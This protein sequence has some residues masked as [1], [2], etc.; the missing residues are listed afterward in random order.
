MPAPQVT[1]ERVTPT[2]L[3][4]DGASWS[5]LVQA[6][7]CDPLFLG[8]D[9]QQL[10]W[11]IYSVP[12]GGTP[13]MYR[14]RGPAGELL[15]I[16]PLYVRRAWRIGP[17]PLRTLEFVGSSWR[18]D[19]TML[20]EYIGPIASPELMPQITAKLLT[21]IEADN[22]CDEFV[23]ALTP[24]TAAFALELAALSQRRGW[25]LRDHDFSRAYHV[26]LREGFEGYLQRLSASSRRHLFN[27]RRRLARQGSLS[28]ESFQ[29]E[30]A[31]TAF[32]TLN[33]LHALRWGGPAFSGKRLQFHQE[34]AARSTSSR[35][36]IVSVLSC[37]AR[38][39]SAL[40]DVR[41]GTRQYNLQMGFDAAA[42]RSVSIGLLHLGHALEQASHAGVCLY[43]MLGGGGKHTQYKAA[44][45]NQHT[46]LHTAQAIRAPVPRM[47]YRLADTIRGRRRSMV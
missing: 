44:L 45:S 11:Q 32:D 40:Y 30:A 27:H 16:V 26:D 33:Q 21:T 20:T 9:W 38:P 17:L 6:A 13:V 47:L 1:L 37:N 25:T 43:D 15:G 39:I 42:N 18:R 3:F 28:F 22:R 36:S 8:Y 46:D 19:S 35:V 31:K 24:S 34:L 2:E 29:G 5:A 4:S 10:W 41:C 12:L 23:A 14:V 7:G